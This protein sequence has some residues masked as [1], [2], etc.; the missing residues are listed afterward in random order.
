MDIVSVNA[1]INACRIGVLAKIQH[2]KRLFVLCLGD[3][4]CTRWMLAGQHVF[5]RRLIAFGLG[6]GPFCA[7]SVRPAS[8]ALTRAG[9]F[10]S[11]S[12]NRL[13]RSGWKV[14]ARPRVDGE[15]YQQ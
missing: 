14:G 5:S 8:G 2:G 10:H 13:C 11:D 9:H 12:H 1:G 3:W 6:G 4:H 15:D 7:L